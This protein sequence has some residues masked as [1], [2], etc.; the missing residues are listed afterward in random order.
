VD[1]DVLGPRG[2]LVF[3]SR[4]PSRPRGTARRSTSWSTSP[5]RVP[6]EP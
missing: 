5:S 1:S 6:P 2:L 4:A 3:F